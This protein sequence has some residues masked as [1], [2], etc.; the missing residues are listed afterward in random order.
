MRCCTINIFFFSFSTLSD[1]ISLNVQFY[2]RE[3]S[4]FLVNVYMKLYT[5]ATT[6]TSAELHIHIYTYRMTCINK[7][8]APNRRILFRSRFNL[9]NLSLFANGLLSLL[10]NQYV[11]Y[12][13]RDYRETKTLL[14][15]IMYIYEA[16]YFFAFW[17][18]CT[19]N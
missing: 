11:I 10:A 6:T 16:I 7:R 18:I 19:R 15:H 17:P 13:E 3:L 2:C 5:F 12:R 8:V 1:S 14:P 9:T 4:H